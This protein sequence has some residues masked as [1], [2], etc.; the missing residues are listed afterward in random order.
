[1]NNFRVT[2]FNPGNIPS[3][4][5]L[6]SQVLV[7]SVDILNGQEVEDEKANLDIN[8]CLSQDAGVAM[9]RV[10]LGYSNF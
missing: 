3:A 8:H 7:L 5:N 9:S 10:A 6:T 2:I 4:T 1:M